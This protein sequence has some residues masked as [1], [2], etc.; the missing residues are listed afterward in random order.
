MLVLFLERALELFDKF[1]TVSLEHI[2]CE[3]NFAANEL[4]Q[5]ATRINLA[6][7]VRERILKVEKRTLPSFMARK[8]DN[9]KW[10][11]AT[12]DGL[13]V[14]WRQP[15]MDYLI[16]PSTIT[17]KQIRFLALNYVLKG[18]ELLRRGENGVDFLCVYGC[19]AQRIIRE[20]HLGICGSHQASP[21]MR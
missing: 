12:V 17:D 7:G 10:L 21:K 19:E 13:D 11:V 1:A 20:V 3:Q 16:N 15:I 2:P 5:I 6:N 9:G 8:E 18:G 14:E 4:A